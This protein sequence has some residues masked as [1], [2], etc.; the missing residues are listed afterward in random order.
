MHS[1][2]THSSSVSALMRAIRMLMQCARCV[3]EE[4]AARRDARARAPRGCVE[5]RAPRGGQYGTR[6]LPCALSVA[7][8]SLLVARCAGEWDVYRHTI[9]H[10]GAATT[11]SSASA[12]W[13]LEPENGTAN[14]VGA[15]WLNGTDAGE[16]SAPARLALRVEFREGAATGRFQSGVDEDNLDTLF[17]FAIQQPIDSVA[18]SVGTWNG[19]E[20]PDAAYVLQANSVTA[21]RFTITVTPRGSDLAAA[22]V[23]AAAA[24]AVKQRQARAAINE[25]DEDAASGPASTG[26]S[27]ATPASLIGAASYI[28]VGHRVRH[29]P[30][31]TLFQQYGTMLM[32]GAMLILNVY[33]RSRQTTQQLTGKAAS[34]NAQ[35]TQTAA[36]RIAASKSRA[37]HSAATIEEIPDAVPAVKKA[38]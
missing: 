34:R 29:E 4:S 20:A 7:R 8:C 31:K 23:A 15:A 5:A 28:Y 32:L 12:R 36:Q 38:L 33:M 25:D 30:A 11:F 37:Q 13:L 27:A 3:L 16:E 10:S 22:A 24:H 1:T 14:L 6:C 26:H 21:D 18:L 9:S 19:A 2:G 17:A 35:I